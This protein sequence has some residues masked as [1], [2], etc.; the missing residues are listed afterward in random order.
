VSPKSKNAKKLK[1]IFLLRN[2]KVEIQS[3]EIYRDREWHVETDAEEN[4]PVKTGQRLEL[5]CCKP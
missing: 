5:S 3:E 2:W 4:G 1:E